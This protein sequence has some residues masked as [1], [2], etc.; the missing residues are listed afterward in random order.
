MSR[1]PAYTVWK[2]AN[3]FSF[4]ALYTKGG[5]GGCKHEVRSS[6]L[7]KTSG[8]CSN[9]TQQHYSWVHLKITHRF[10]LLSHVAKHDVPSDTAAPWF[11]L[12][13]LVHT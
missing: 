12:C 6:V 3:T 7:W 2:P 1:N 4:T 8:C 5:G 13:T 10:Q 9:W 11:P